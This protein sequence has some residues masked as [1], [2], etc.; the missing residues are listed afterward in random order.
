M[1]T[2]YF[3][4]LEQCDVIE[5]AF[6]KP[7]G[8]E[9]ILPLLADSGFTGQSCF[10]LP[11][12]AEDLAQAAAPASQTAGALSGAQRRVVVTCRIPGLAFHG[13][14]TAILADTSSLALPPGIE[15][16]AGLRF[17]RYFRRWGAER[18]DDNSWRFLLS[19]E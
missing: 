15:G 8:G 1:P 12:Y 5:V 19:D 7:A 11:L 10:V 16:M 3:R 6:L 13:S 4:S 2:A 14:F 9:V 18:A 17:L